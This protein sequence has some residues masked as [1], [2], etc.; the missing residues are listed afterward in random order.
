MQLDAGVPG[1]G[2]LVSALWVVGGDTLVDVTAPV[3]RLPDHP[4]AL[5]LGQDLAV[6]PVA[7]VEPGEGVPHLHTRHHHSPAQH[8]GTLPP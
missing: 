4:A 6:E 2:A 1:Q 7:G 8:S 3:P 5:Q